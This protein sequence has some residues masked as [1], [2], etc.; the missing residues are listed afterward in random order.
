MNPCRAFVRLDI[1]RASNACAAAGW[2]P[3]ETAANAKTTNEFKKMARF[4]WS[5]LALTG[6]VL[7]TSVLTGC[8]YFAPRSRAPDAEHLYNGI[9]T[10]DVGYVQA[11]IG[12]GKAS[13]N[14]RIPAPGYS[15][16]TPLITIAARAA[17]LN[18]LRYLI[19]AGANL[20][21]R[22]PA[23][24]TA[25]MLACFFMD[26]REWL[27]PTSYE[28]HERAARMLVDAGADLESAPHGYTALSYAAYQGRDRTVRFLLTRGAR[29]DGYAQD[30]ITYIPTPLMMAAM[31]GHRR[32]AFYLLQS[33]AN[34]R[35]RVHQ[36][37]TAREL[38]AKH[39]QSHVI[40]VLRCAESLAPGESFARRCE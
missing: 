39:G 31:M 40:P 13:V 18:V 14:Q 9:L 35:I 23:H 33:G 16:G 7:L 28:R 10:D 36:G 6:C 2:G 27:G 11:V 8:G 17:S 32:T 24:E 21:A 1:L 25:L 34:A 20:N 12:S 38:A 26:D 30:G 29:V 22:S 4:S 37:H 19:K 3:V 15:E 5:V